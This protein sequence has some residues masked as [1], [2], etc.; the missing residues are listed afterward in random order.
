[1]TPGAACETVVHP[2]ESIDALRATGDDDR[3]GRRAE[4]ALLESE[5]RHAA[6]GIAGITLCE[7]RAISAS[8]G[9]PH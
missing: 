9:S 5:E 1:M 8:G 2:G 4:R 7:S 6:V 3:E